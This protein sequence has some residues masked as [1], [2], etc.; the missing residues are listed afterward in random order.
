MDIEH[1][2]VRL[3]CNLEPRL[4]G[5]ASRWSWPPRRDDTTL[6]HKEEAFH[7]TTPNCLWKGLQFH[8]EGR[9]RCKISCS[10]H[11]MKKTFNIFVQAAETNSKNS[12]FKNHAA[13]PD[14]DRQLLKNKLTATLAY[15][16]CTWNLNWPI[17]VQQAENTVLSWRQMYVNR[18]GIEER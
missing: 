6:L 1:A 15:G 2:K 5:L 9:V 8:F 11:E 13:T 10:S 7:Y 16:R 14:H 17:K 4:H 18:K 3:E 12:W